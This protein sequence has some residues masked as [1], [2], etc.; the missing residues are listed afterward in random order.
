M[1]SHWGKTRSREPKKQQKSLQ[2]SDPSGDTL[3]CSDSI[4]TKA[5]ATS[6][7]RA[8]QEGTDDTTSRGSG[9]CKVQALKYKQKQL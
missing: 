1:E 4:S 5:P 8:A 9:G 7:A 6:E 3:D 2:L